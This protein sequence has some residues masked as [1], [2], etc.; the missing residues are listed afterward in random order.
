MPTK[1]NESGRV[2]HELAVA[3]RKLLQKSE[4][5]KLRK[6]ISNAT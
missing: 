4:A 6:E 5:Q 2:L 1:R 3:V